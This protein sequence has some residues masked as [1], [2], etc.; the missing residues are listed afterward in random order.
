MAAVSTPYIRTFAGIV[1][2][3]PAITACRAGDTPKSGAELRRIV[4]HS[5]HLGA[6]GMGYGE[7]SLVELS[8]KI[9][10]A[11]I[12]TLIDLLNDRS[13][14]TGVGF[15]LASQCEASIV[16]VREAAV[17]H[18]MDFGE[19]QEVLDV[20]AGFR[21]CTP[22]AQ[23]KAVAMRADIIALRDAAQARIEE[24]AKKR[25]SED[26]RIQQNALKMIDPKQAASLSRKERE[27][28][29]RRSLKAMG[30]D[31]NG[32]LTPQQRD[33]IDRMYRTMVLGQ[34][35]NPKPQ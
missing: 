9:V 35:G 11:D 8:E 20:I 32:P 24:E 34:P 5:Q 26:T 29:Y 23:Q 7:R 15:A 21:A 19:A 4:L 30:L 10:P 27:E 25:A 14:R 2:C 18:K 6:H 31:E 17:Q 16:P 22:E 28:V 3:L 13:L 1:L 12:P 33:L